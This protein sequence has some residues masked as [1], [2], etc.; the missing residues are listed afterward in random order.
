M[1]RRDWGRQNTA[2]GHG[3]DRGHCSNGTS[4]NRRL[5][6][7]AGSGRIQE[8]GHMRLAG[9]ATASHIVYSK[10]PLKLRPVS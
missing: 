9:A 2:M 8:K 5:E 6:G 4:L 3:T 7:E 10:T 1:T